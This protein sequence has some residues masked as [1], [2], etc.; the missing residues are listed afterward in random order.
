MWKIKFTDVRSFIIEWKRIND[1]YGN[2]NLISRFNPNFDF[3][4]ALSVKAKSHFSNPYLIV[5]NK[6]EYLFKFFLSNDQLEIINFK[7]VKDALDCLEDIDD[8][9]NNYFIEDKA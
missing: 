8:F 4:Y 1:F 2:K 3:N 6:Q 5:F 7:L 9:F